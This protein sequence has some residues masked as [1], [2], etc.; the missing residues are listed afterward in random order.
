MEVEGELLCVVEPCWVREKLEQFIETVLME[1][2]S[3]RRRKPFY[4]RVRDIFTLVF[5][6]VLGP[7]NGFW[8]MYLA[9][10]L[11]GS[12]SRLDRYAPTHGNVQFK[13]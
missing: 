2:V 3:Q 12:T 13:T 9:S 7:Q 5:I 4:R 10:L 8:N 1:I 11:D 6:L